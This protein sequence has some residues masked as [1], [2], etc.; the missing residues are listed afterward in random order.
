MGSGWM[1]LC[2]PLFTSYGLFLRPFGAP[3]DTGDHTMSKQTS[4]QSTPTT[5][6]FAELTFPEGTDPAAVLEALEQLNRLTAQLFCGLFDEGENPDDDFVSAVAD[7][8]EV[9]VVEDES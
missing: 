1:L 6:P 2:S 9:R 3:L 5:E 7:C 4:D 8:L